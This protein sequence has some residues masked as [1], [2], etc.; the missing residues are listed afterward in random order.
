MDR[1][2]MTTA[3]LILATLLGA[4][5]SGAAPSAGPV[6]GQQPEAGS[7]ASA[8][9]TPAGGAPAIG[10]GTT[11]KLTVANGPRTGSYSGSSRESICTSGQIF[12]AG[13]FGVQFTDPGMQ[14][15]KPE[16]FTSFQ[17]LADN[18]KDGVGNSEAFS[19]LVQF[20]PLLGAGGTAYA[21]EPSARAGGRGTATVEVRGTDK[22]GTLQAGGSATVSVKG[23]TKDGVKLEVRVDC[24]A[25]L[26]FGATASTPAP[27]K[28]AFS[29]TLTGGSSP[30]KYEG[31]SDDV[32]CSATKVEGSSRVEWAAAY[33]VAAEPASVDGIAS[34]SFEAASANES[35][36][37]TL[38]VDVK[39]PGQPAASFTL[40]PAS[41]EGTGSAVVD[42]RGATATIRVNGQTKNGV[43]IEVRLDCADI[44]R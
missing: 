8:A 29:V 15:A 4:C 10:S 20:G 40:A 11:V 37:L 30:G 3:T 1:H 2:V 28:G 24:H 6:T 18:A 41:G 14:Q 42:D 38:T 26:N 9:A 19:A 17:F 34:I 35:Q 27:A 31:R 25:V 39:K 22:P 32:Q 16:T 44:L 12:R 21:I 36:A 13:Q 33:D 23:E 7:A 43:R 5:S